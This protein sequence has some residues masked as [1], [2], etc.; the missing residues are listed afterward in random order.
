[1]MSKINYLESS[2][3]YKG[4]HYSILKPYMLEYLHKR[5]AEMFKQ[6]VKIFNANNIQY[7][8]CGGTLL[9]AYTTGRFIPWDDDLDVCVFEEDY[10]KAAKCLIR[11]LSDGA[12]LQCPKT[13]SNYYL[14]WMKVRDQFSHVHPDAPMFK[15]NGVWID[16]YKLIKVEEKDIPFVVAEENIG[17]L[18]RRL[19]AGGMTKE[20]YKQRVISGELIEKLEAAKEKAEKSTIKGE[21]YI[22]WS[23]SKVSIKKDWLFPLRKLR[24]EGICVT[25]FDKAESYL[26]Q[27]YGEKFNEFPADECR[28]VGIN[29]IELLNP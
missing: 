8:I 7:M 12:V 11:D 29:K 2:R 4:F 27:H 26:R 9:G 16:I 23:A 10:E 17:Y 6:V 19:S 3:V 28:R 1:M 14:G 25:T 15:E 22:I 13:D 18:K 24:F 20:E 5:T 21:E